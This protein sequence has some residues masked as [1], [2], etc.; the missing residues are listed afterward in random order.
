MQ[1]KPT[2]YDYSDTY[3]SCL[4]TT[5]NFV[6][7]DSEGDSVMAQEAH[8]LRKET[9][10]HFILPHSI[11]FMSKIWRSPPYA[12]LSSWRKTKYESNKLILYESSNLVICGYISTFHPF[13]LPG[14]FPLSASSS[15]HGSHLFLWEPYFVL[16]LRMLHRLK[17]SEQIFCPLTLV[18]FT[19]SN[20]YPFYP[21]IHIHSHN[22]MG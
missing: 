3:I 2:P 15:S 10:T 18:G 19:Q 5:P 14:T 13:S 4:P 12:V 1:S 6:K 22:Y 9:L 11:V 21:F 16:L 7:E 17:S 20:F 8:S